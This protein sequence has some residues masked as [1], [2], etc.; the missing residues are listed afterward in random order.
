MHRI[1]HAWRTLAR[2]HAT[3]ARHHATG[4][5]ALRNEDF[6]SPVRTKRDDANTRKLIDL[7]ASTATPR[8]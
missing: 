3:H 6:V 5:M 7:S 2:N 1:S 8:E 4:G